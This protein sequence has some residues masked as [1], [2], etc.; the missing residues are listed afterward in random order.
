MFEQA[1]APSGVCVLPDAAGF[2]LVFTASSPFRMWP[3]VLSSTALRQLPVC[4]SAFEAE[5]DGSEGADSSD[6]SSVDSG[7]SDCSEGDES[8][9]GDDGPTAHLQPA[10]VR[11]H[12]AGVVLQPRIQLRYTDGR[13]AASLPRL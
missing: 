12:P 11:K 1:R 13:A 4:E 10:I 7:G 6:G 8:G 2:V 5:S 9:S 3:S